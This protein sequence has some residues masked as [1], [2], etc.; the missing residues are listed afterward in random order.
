MRLRVLSQEAAEGTKVVLLGDPYQIDNP[1]LDSNSN[2]L[3]YVIEKMR[4]AKYL[5]IH[6]PF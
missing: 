5:W 6:K 4:G 2:G 1:Y 3:V